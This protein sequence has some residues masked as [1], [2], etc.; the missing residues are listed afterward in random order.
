MLLL[1]D[2][3]GPNYCKMLKIFSALRI[4]KF[5]ALDVIMN[6]NEKVLPSFSQTHHASK[7]PHC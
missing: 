2:Y 5:V 7:D 1:Y 6:H 4:D 3:S